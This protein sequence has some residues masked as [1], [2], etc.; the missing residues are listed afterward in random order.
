MNIRR[1][2]ITLVVCLVVTA[3]LAS[4]KILQIRSAIAFAES[5]PEHSET[6][7]LQVARQIEYT[8]VVNVTGEAVAPK[9]VELTNELSGRIAA[10]NTK[11]GARVAKGQVIVQLD[12]SEEEAR[13]R[14]A[15][16]R[17]ELAKLAY[18]RQSNLIKTN[19]ASQAQLDEARAELQVIT[20][21]IEVLN[22]TINKKTIKA[23]FNGV[24][25]LHQLEAGNFLQSNALITTVVG[26]TGY[27][28]VDFS[29]PQFYIHLS[30]GDPVEARLVQHASNRHERFFP[31]EVVAREATIS[32]LS[33]SRRYRAML[34]TDSLL[35]MHNAV[36]EVKVP[37]AE[38]RQVVAVP[39]L[40]VQYDALGPYVYL[41]LEGEKEGTYRAR[42]RELVIGPK[43]GDLV[44]VSSGLS[45]GDLIAGAG[46]F[47]LKPGMLVYT[48]EP[49]RV[50]LEPAPN[51]FVRTKA[52]AETGH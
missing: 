45:E 26:S 28:W 13:L 52:A 42:R 2:S 6:V 30:K 48:R 5:F 41:L 11:S 27:V 31:G 3:A 51:T 18:Q 49:E 8:P 24:V 10:V 46:A 7:E 39:S 36:M 37:V 43:Q 23:P 32:S 4:F 47:K 14:S 40:A 33:R 50:T 1:W 25:G 35:F 15:R 21:E 9:R 17:E 20:S 29:L 44:T 34:S 16:A 22:S 19:A 12:I 38:P